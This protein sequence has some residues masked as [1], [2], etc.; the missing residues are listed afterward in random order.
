MRVD[1]QCVVVLIPG[2]SPTSP[3]TT[4]AGFVFVLSVSAIKDAYE[5]YQRY[6]YKVPKATMNWMAIVFRNLEMRAAR[7]RHGASK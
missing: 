1:V 5:D 4:I 6:V 2:M 3:A 7:F